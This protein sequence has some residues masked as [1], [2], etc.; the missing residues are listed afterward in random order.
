M[1]IKQQII[2]Q[3]TQVIA[4]DKC[5]TYFLRTSSTPTQDNVLIKKATQII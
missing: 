1:K 2:L 5:L 3:V 4:E